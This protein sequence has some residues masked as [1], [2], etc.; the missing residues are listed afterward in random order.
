MVP[1]PTVLVGIAVPYAEAKHIT[2]LVAVDVPAVMH[3]DSS[4][5]TPMDPQEIMRNIL[6][7]P[8]LNRLREQEIV[9]HGLKE[10]E[11]PLHFPPLEDY[12][13]LKDR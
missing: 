2:P 9:L 11:L 10:K 1:N 7:L 4:W 8:T 13:P 3:L 6:D 5:L 12:T